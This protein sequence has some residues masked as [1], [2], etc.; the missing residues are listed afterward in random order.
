MEMNDF[1]DLIINQREGD[2]T[3][4]WKGTMLEYLIKV[5][6]NPEITNIC[7]NESIT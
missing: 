5:R 3:T 7:P 2:Q 1:R 4:N 6:D